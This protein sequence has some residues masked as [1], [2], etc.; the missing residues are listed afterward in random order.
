MAG[1]GVSGCKVSTTRRGLCVR[2]IARELAAHHLVVEGDVVAVGALARVPAV[3]GDLGANGGQFED[4]TLRSIVALQPSSE[5]RRRP[6]G[7]GA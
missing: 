6:Q 3:L 5:R 7:E 4:L 1:A 2:Q